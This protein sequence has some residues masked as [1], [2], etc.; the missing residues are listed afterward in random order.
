MLKS[1]FQQLEA[2]LSCEF[3]GTQSGQKFRLR[4]KGFPV[5]RSPGQRG[6]QYVEVK[7]VLPSVISEETKEL[8]RQYERLNPENPRKS[9][10]VE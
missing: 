8:L 3:T 1:K 5:L 9:L 7:I 4:E 6:D 10:G 2:K